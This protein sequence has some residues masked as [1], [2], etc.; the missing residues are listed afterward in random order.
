[1][2]IENPA[3]QKAVRQI[4]AL[5]QDGLSLAHIAEQMER[6]GVRTKNGAGWYPST[7]ARILA[8][9]RKLKT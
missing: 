6:E 1:M 7:V 8:R 3:E 2:L 9:Y 4:V 5:R